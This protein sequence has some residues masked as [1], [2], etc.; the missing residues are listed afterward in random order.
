MTIDEQ[1]RDEKIQYDARIARITQESF[2]F[3]KKK[4][5]LFW[6]FHKDL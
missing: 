5:K 2:S 1:I 4:K 3:L 6:T